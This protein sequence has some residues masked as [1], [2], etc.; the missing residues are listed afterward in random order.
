MTSKE[1][2]SQAFYLNTQI[3]AKQKRLEWLRD[4]AP[5]PTVR[6][7]DELR[8]PGNPRSSLVEN[9]ALKVVELEEEIASDIMKLVEIT[10]DIESVIRA[11]DSIEYRTLLEM[12]YLGFMDWDEIASRMGY[13]PRNVFYVHSREIRTVHI[14][15]A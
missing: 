11:V 13:S 7:T 1:Y 14:P 15:A 6:F 8:G 4:I 12:R 10:K 5:G 3:K 9:A 2:L